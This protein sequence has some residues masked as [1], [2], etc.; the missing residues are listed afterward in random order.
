MQLFNSLDP[1]PLLNKDLDRSAEA[2]IENWAMLFP[3]NSRLRTMIHVEHLLGAGNA[4]ALMTEAIHNR[5]AY[6]ARLAHG[7]LR[8][9]L[10]RGRA[11]LFIGLVFIE[12]CLTAADAIAQLGSGGAATI[13]RESLTIIGWVAMWRPVEMFL[14][15]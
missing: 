2:Y 13:A 7:G 3:S 11:S 5:F 9:L 8:Q 10:R 6:K 15:D 1:T 12:V 4:T 14:Y